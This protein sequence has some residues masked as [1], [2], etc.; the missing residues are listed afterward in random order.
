MLLV[1]GFLIPVVWFVAAKGYSYI[2]TFLLFFLW[3]FLFVP[4]LLFVVG[5]FVWGYRYVIVGSKRDEESSVDGEPV[6]VVTPGARSTD[7]R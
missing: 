5:S 3:Y 4:A 1:I 2:H 6:S 7:G